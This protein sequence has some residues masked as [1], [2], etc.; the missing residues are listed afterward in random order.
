M[1]KEGLLVDLRLNQVSR[2]RIL[3]K[4]VSFDKL[5]PLVEVIPRYT[6]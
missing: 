3:A 6:K 2:L 4:P 1:D 5:D